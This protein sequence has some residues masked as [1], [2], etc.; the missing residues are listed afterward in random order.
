K[1]PHDRFPNAIAM[2]RAIQDILPEGGTLLNGMLARVGGTGHDILP[3]PVMH[4][5]VNDAPGRT[6]DPRLAELADPATPEARRIEIGE[7]LG[8]EGDPRLTEDARWIEIREGPFWRGA[9]DDDEAAREDEKPAGKVE[10]GMYWIERW[11]VTLGD[12]ARFVDDWK[13]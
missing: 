7:A 9:A 2:L 5:T 6:A 12:Y 11:V 1:D 10:V 4:T 3:P 13:G 8:R